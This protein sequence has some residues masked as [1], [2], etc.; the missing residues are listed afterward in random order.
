MTFFFFFFFFA[1]GQYS[2]GHILCCLTHTG[3]KPYGC[4]DCGK[5]FSQQVNCRHHQLTHGGEKPFQCS[6]CGMCF[7]H[8]YNWAL[9]L[10]TEMDESICIIGH[11][12][13]HCF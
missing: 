12:P 8:N 7:S 3:E 11:P 2:P 1:P 13:S 10:K 6:E 9:D 5:R 4:P